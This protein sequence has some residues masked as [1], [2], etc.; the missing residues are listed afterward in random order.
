VPT[1]KRPTKEIAD[2]I[3]KVTLVPNLSCLFST[4]TGFIQEQFFDIV[5]VK[6]TTTLSLKNELC[7]V[8]F[9]HNLNV[10]NIR[11]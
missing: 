3:G 6:D 1:G 2:C 5:H 4:G 8:L 10:S 9:R 11:G 7:V